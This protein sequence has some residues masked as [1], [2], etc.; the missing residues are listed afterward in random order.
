MTK[1]V[2][3]IDGSSY[4]GPWTGAGQ[5]SKYLLPC[6]A[7]RGWSPVLFLN[8][9]AFPKWEPLAGVTIVR[10]PF[11]QL[12]GPLRTAAAALTLPS[13]YR[14]YGCQLAW[15]ETPPSPGNLPFVLTIHDA[16]TWQVPNSVPLVRKAWSKLTIPPALQRAAVITTVSQSTARAL[17]HYFP[18]TDVHVV[19][20]AGPPSQETSRPRAVSQEGPLILS[21]GPWDSLRRPALV[22]RALTRLKA[23]HPNLTWRLTGPKP[24]N[25]ALPSWA[26][27]SLRSAED[28]QIL[29]SSAHALVADSVCEGFNL[30]IVEALGHQCP[31]VASDIPVHHEVG[32]DHIHYFTDSAQLFSQLESIITHP[33]PVEFMG[34]SWEDCAKEME[35]VMTTVLP[36]G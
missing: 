6:L 32:G 5:R 36:S 29:Y 20:N 7:E 30:P 18:N 25:L 28:L 27:W 16:R 31:V 22:L 21:V 1:K 33:R 15:T 2:I 12:P 8:A 23:V 9:T 34:R 13:L 26:Q 11:P 24:P 35:A 14:K 19:P 17:Q 10:L 3:G 4:A